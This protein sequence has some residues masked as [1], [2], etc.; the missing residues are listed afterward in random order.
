VAVTQFEQAEL[1]QI[2]GDR[3]AADLPLIAVLTG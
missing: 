3:T 1:R 2:I